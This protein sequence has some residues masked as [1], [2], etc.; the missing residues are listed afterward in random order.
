MATHSKSV[1]TFDKAIEMGEYR[2]EVLA[3]Y[4]EW[5]ELSPHVQLQHIRTGIDNRMKQLIT[6]W[7]EIN[8]VIDFHLKP[9]LQSALRNIEAQMKKLD[10]DREELYLEYSS[11][12]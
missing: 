11:K 1:L 4:P 9:H 5:H 12:L 10:H 3:N 6:Q 7:A 8:N 2:P